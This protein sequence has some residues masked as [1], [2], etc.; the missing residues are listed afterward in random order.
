M[1]ITFGHCCGIIC[2]SGLSGYCSSIGFTL[3]FPRFVVVVLVCGIG[4]QIWF[5]RVI[6]G[7]HLTL[8]C[9]FGV[10]S[11]TVVQLVLELSFGLI[12]HWLLGYLIGILSSGLFWEFFLALGYILGSEE[13][14]RAVVL[15]QSISAS[16]L[17]LT[18]KGR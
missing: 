11:G 1:G 6:V 10:Y 13:S 8:G 15:G 12:V 5:S 9:I 18:R 14:G 2:T 16:N 3:G 4:L 7:Q 17:S